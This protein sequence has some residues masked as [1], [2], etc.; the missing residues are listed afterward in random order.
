MRYT[1]DLPNDVRTID[2]AVRQLMA[3]CREAGFTGERLRLNF[4]VGV[5]EALT[6]AMLYGNAGDPAKHVHV[7]ATV[8]PDRVIIKVSD[9]GH[10]FD[11]GTVPDPTLPPNRLRTGGRG[12]F[13][14]RKMM[15]RVEYNRAGNTVTMILYARPRTARQRVPGR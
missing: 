7:E 1:L 3:R 2:R 11:P 6:N 10:G 5:T 12:V 13:L 4:R 14:I 15:D 9:E 8:A